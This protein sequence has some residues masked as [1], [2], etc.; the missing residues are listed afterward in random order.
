MTNPDHLV[1]LGLSAIR[2]SVGLERRSVSHHP[3]AAPERRGDASVIRISK[4]LCEFAIFD[5]PGVFA[6]KLEFISVVVDRPGP[7]R[8]HQDASLDRS[9]DRF[10]RRAPW[11]EIDV[12]HAIDGRT[13][14]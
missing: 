6:S 7:I 11:L 1:R 14:P 8:V 13:I 10:K 12:R 2:R 9:D 5:P 4:G 3:Q